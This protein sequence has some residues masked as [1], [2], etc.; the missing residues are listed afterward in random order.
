MLVDTLNEQLVKE[1]GTLYSNY[2]NND[3]KI[4]AQDKASKELYVK[5]IQAS[6][7]I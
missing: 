6:D 1:S 7:M 3:Y 5:A 2:K 4:A